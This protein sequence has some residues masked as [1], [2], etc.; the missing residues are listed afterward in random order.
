[1]YNIL[2]LRYPRD[3]LPFFSEKVP[4]IFSRRLSIVNERVS[5]MFSPKLMSLPFI[6]NFSF[7]SVNVAN[8]RVF[9]TQKLHVQE[10]HFGNWANDTLEQIE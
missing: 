7:S 5:V 10:E 4:D 8:G 9:S 1:M 2:I 3:N 6:V